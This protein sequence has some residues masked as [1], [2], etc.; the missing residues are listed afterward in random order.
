MTINDN[1]TPLKSKKSDMNYL[2]EKITQVGISQKELAN[3]LQKNVVTVNRWVNDLRHISPENAIEIAK[4]IKCDP[5]AILFPPKKLNKLTIKYYTD[6]SYM[7]KGMDKRFHKEVIVPNGYSSEATIAVNY[8]KIG[9]QHHNQVHLFE[10]QKVGSSTEGF[11]EDSINR[12][13]YIEPTMKIAKKMG[14]TPVMAL[15][16]INETKSN[17]RLDLLHVKTE[18]PVNDKSVAI[19]PDWIKVCAPLKMTFFEKFNT[20]I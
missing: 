1:V 13:C 5:A 16:R 12:I 7:V 18:K 2:K 6:D 3:K 11:H 20:N 4:I 8:Y 14:C 10:A 15:V 19:D 17:Y 9:S